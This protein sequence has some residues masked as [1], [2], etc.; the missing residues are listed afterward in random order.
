MQKVLSLAHLC[1]DS[2]RLTTDTPKN[3][4]CNLQCVSFYSL[5]SQ[6]FQNNLMYKAFFFLIFKLRLVMVAGWVSMPSYSW[7]FFF[8]NKTDK[9]YITL[10]LSQRR[11]NNPRQTLDATTIKLLTK[12]PYH[13]KNTRYVCQDHIQQSIKVSFTSVC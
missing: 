6:H 5:N 9:I 10:K 12:G 3:S 7:D 2:S 13:L 4:Y 8:F 1:P 11:K